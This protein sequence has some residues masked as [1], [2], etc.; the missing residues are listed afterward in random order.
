MATN[1]NVTNG[2]PRQNEEN[3][4]ERERE[5][6]LIDM[7]NDL[8]SKLVANGY[9]LDL[10][11]P[12]IVVVGSQSAG[13][14]SVLENIVGREFLPRGCGV[15]TRRPTL[16][17]LYPTQGE[18]YAVFGHRENQKFTDFNAVKEEIIAQMPPRHSFSSVPIE[19]KIYSPRVLK[20]TLVDL[21]E[22]V[23]VAVDGQPEGNILEVRNMVL[24]Y[25][26]QP[27]SLILAVSPANQ[28]L[29]TS[30]ALEIA[31]TVDPQR[32][33]TIGVLTKLDLM[34]EGTDARDILE[35]RQVTLKRGWVGVLNRSQLDIDEGRDI[36]FILE[37]ERRFFTEKA[38]YRHLAERMG[39]PYLQKMLQRTLKSHIKAA[40]PDVRTKLAEKLAGY[41]K[42]LKD[43]GDTMGEESG[44]KQ[45][46]MIKL[47]NN[48]IKDI[49]LK[50]LGNSEMV[51]M[52]AVSAGA[53]INFK[54][55]T[56]VQ[57]NLKLNLVPKDEDMTIV[58][59]NLHG[60]RGSISFPSLALDSINR[61]LVAEYEY[62]MEKS[63]ECVR[64]V[65]EEAISESA[66]MLNKYPA[67]K[68]EVLFR[69]NRCLLKECENTQMKLREHV[70]A[71]MFYVNLEHPDMDLSI[72]DP[73][74]PAVGPTKVW[75]SVSEEDTLPSTSIE[76][77]VDDGLESKTKN[78][79]K[80]LMEN[81][82][83]KKKVQYLTLVMTKYLEI[84]QKQISD[85]T[86]KY[87]LCFL[88]KKVLDYIKDDLVPTL[89]DLSN[90]ASLTEDCE[91]DFRLKEEMEAACTCIKDAL[92]AI[93]AF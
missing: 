77:G 14:S 63:V 32:L 72:C 49:E 64:K 36:Q 79:L 66:A 76:N 75:H 43:F 8:Q 65:L 10:S 11:L 4:Q 50:L 29:A 57:N 25:I 55:N 82:S 47:V 91:E 92:D 24:N 9:S 81:E 19:L 3:E 40:L 53:Y 22:L 21:P 46:Y 83:T 18:E 62:P 73:V 59:T 42:K 56:E 58:I 12:Q 51:N 2:A 37:K 31:R 44:G 30:D 15:V 39:T 89:L 60:I 35:N 87:I 1:R 78:L 23:R 84:V 88:V 28:D 68:A 80:I 61:K 7:M 90:F 27:E 38:C 34:D 16:I 52:N 41:R 54:L 71:E 48:F 13:K 45:Y 69:I 17:Q 67:T 20:L 26:R 6:D 74:V 85:L 70:Q 93:Q 86:V 5:R 33:R